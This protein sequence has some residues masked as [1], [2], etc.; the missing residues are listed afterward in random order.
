[1]EKEKKG[2]SSCKQNGKEKF[3][4]MMVLGTYLFITSIYGN[5]ILIDK[6]ITYLKTLF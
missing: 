5:V 3:G 4:W 2:C 6:L 1:M